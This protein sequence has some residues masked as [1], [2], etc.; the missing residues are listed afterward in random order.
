MQMLFHIL[1]RAESG[2]MKEAVLAIDERSKLVDIQVNGEKVHSLKSSQN[3]PRKSYG[4]KKL[5]LFGQHKS[6]AKLH[7]SGSNTSSNTA[8]INYCILLMEHGT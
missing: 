8:T 2:V 6:L 1:G 7:S 5:H 4:C 3:K